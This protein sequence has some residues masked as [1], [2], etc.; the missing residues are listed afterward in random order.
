[1]IN[2]AVYTLY[3]GVGSAAKP[4]AAST[5]IPATSRCP[6]AEGAGRRYHSA[7]RITIRAKTPIRRRG[8]ITK[9][10]RRGHRVRFVR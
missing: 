4:A 2:E 8:F 10:A 1:M 5:T 6:R 7:G 3:E 9:L